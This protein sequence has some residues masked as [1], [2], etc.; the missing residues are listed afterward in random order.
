SN[1][2]ASPLI[3]E[4]SL[5]AVGFVG[6]QYLPSDS[7]G[8][9]GGGGVGGGGNFAYSSYS[10]SK[11]SNRLHWST[12]ITIAILLLFILLLIAAV[13]F[14]AA[15]S[16]DLESRIETS[17]SQNLT[18]FGL[19][20]P[21]APP[22]EEIS[23]TEPLQISLE[24]TGYWSGKLTISATCYLLVNVSLPYQQVVG[25]YLRRNSLPTAVRHDFFH[26]LVNVQS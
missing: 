4:S 3:N 5:G 19:F 1:K 25:L 8:G 16:A 9:G 12:R 14:F 26:R 10:A 18:L 2:L 23:T 22:P 15:R 20:D 17:R 7:S 6:G 13:G 21:N 24:P 11:K